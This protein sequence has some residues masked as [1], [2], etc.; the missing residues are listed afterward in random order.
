MSILITGAAGFIGS[1]FA[2]K[3]LEQGETCILVDNFSGYYSPELKRLR[4]KEFLV[5]PFGVNVIDINLSDNNWMT[6][7]DASQI[8]HVFHLAAQPGVRVVYPESLNY[9]SSNILGFS[10]VLNWTLRN[11]IPNFVYASSSSVYQNSTTLPFKED[12]VIS[13]P[14]NIY[15]R[16]KWMNEKIIESLI[17]QTSTQAIGLRFFSVYGPW[18]RPDMAYSKLLLAALDPQY[19]FRQNGNGSV[20]RDF[21]FIGDVIEIMEKIYSLTED[22]PKI[23]NIGGGCNVSINEL[24]DVIQKLTGSS[25]KKVILENFQGDA[26]ATLASN[27]LTRKL[28]AKSEYTSIENGIKQ[29]LNWLQKNGNLDILRNAINLK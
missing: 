24:T 19:V 21:T 27:E 4:V 6:N 14:N 29:T 13:M 8:T 9:L 15:A 7:I 2:K 12:F 10:S 3:M 5:K 20:R 23:L 22:Y 26:A 16:T 18:G 11:L 25:I 1:H 28:F 17:D